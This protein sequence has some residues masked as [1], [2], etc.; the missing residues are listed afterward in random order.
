MTQL[1]GNDTWKWE[2][3]QQTAF[4]TL[5]ETVMNRIYPLVSFFISFHFFSL[6]IHFPSHFHYISAY[7]YFLSPIPTLSPSS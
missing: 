5:K 2:T 6:Y 4:D 1:T 3:E 7:S